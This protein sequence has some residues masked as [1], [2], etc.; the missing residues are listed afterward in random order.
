MFISIQS[1]SLY[2]LNQNNINSDSGFTPGRRGSGERHRERSRRGVHTSGTAAC[3][4]VSA[5]QLPPIQRHSAAMSRHRMHHFSKRHKR[6]DQSERRF[7]LL[8]LDSHFRCL[9]Q[10]RTWQSHNFESA[11]SSVAAYLRLIK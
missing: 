4:A 3:V 5:A 9:G 2:A 6:G 11:L 7:H 8:Q 10:G 1:M